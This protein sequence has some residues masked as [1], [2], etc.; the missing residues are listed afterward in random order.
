MTAR[1]LEPNEVELYSIRERLIFE[2]RWELARRFLDYWGRTGGNRHGRTVVQAF[3]SW[4]A[5]ELPN[6]VSSAW[7]LDRYPDLLPQERAALLHAV[8]HTELGQRRIRLG[9]GRRADKFLENVR[10]RR[11][12]PT[13]EDI[14]RLQRGGDLSHL[15]PDPDD[16][17]DVPMDSLS[18]VQAI[19][20][21]LGFIGPD[22]GGPG[23]LVG[24]MPEA[25][26]VVVKPE[27]FQMSGQV[28][29]EEDEDDG[30]PP[31]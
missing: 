8:T 13:E 9:R 12:R 20:A 2:K 11:A 31:F 16:P 24:D 26:L 17:E 21:G 5:R 15:V 7:S 29:V 4:A 23:Q 25:D 18:R 3:E 30:E 14:A 22:D 10:D 19:A 27:E 28:V 6:M 1:Q